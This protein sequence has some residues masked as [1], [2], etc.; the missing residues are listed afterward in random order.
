VEVDR[1]LLS[2]RDTYASVASYEDHGIVR[3]VAAGER[4]VLGSFVTRFDRQQRSFYFDFF[5]HDVEEFFSIHFEGETLKR[6]RPE[7]I[8]A[9]TIGEATAKL[10]GIT[11]GCAHN[12]LAMLVPSMVGG[13]PLWDCGTSPTFHAEVRSGSR[14]WVVDVQGP[15]A[16]QVVIRDEDWVVLGHTLRGGAV[17]EEI[18]Q[19]AKARGHEVSPILLVPSVVVEYEPLLTMA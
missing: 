17:G 3:A 18:V 13:R 10:T 1:V 2:M 15:L 5:R 6:L 19:Q 11:F 12:I 8:N 4:P 9:K 7:S 14:C 16:E